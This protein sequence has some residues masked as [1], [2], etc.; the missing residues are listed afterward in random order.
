MFIVRCCI[1]PCYLG[2]YCVAMPFCCLHLDCYFVAVLSRACWSVN[3][4]QCS[5]AVCT[6][7]VASLS[8]SFCRC[9]TSCAVW[10]WMSRCVVLLGL[11]ECLRLSSIFSLYCVVRCVAVAVSRCR[12]SGLVLLSLCVN[13]VCVYFTLLV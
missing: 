3:V 11:L 1:K 2:C 13:N 4:S 8:V 6:S 7:T 12:S 10:L 9:I 5:S